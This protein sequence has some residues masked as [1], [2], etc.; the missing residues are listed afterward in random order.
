MSSPTEA[1]PSPLPRAQSRLRLHRDRQPPWTAAAGTRTLRWFAPRTFW[2]FGL[3]NGHAI[4]ER[5]QGEFQITESDI[6]PGSVHIRGGTRIALVIRS[7]GSIAVGV[8][9]PDA[10]T[11]SATVSGI[12]E[13]LLVGAD[14]GTAVATDHVAGRS[15]V[16]IGY[17][18]ALP[19]GAVPGTRPWPLALTVRSAV[20]SLANP[21]AIESAVRQTAGGRHLPGNVDRQRSL[22]SAHAI[23]N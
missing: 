13:P 6:V 14:G 3:Q 8:H 20:P 7:A 23:S 18:F 4:V 16:D 19:L 10:L 21:M 22:E 17:H 11:R 12:G 9:D 15:V 1:P 5:Q 2:A